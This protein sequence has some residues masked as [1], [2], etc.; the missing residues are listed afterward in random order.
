MVR[1][2]VDVGSNS[3][4]TLVARRDGLM[5]SPV[6]ELSRVTGLGKGVRSS[7]LLSTESMS[8]T[9]EALAEAFALARS[10]GASR[11]YAGATMA[12]RMATNTADFVAAAA[13]QGTPL[14]VLSS[15]EEARLGFFAVAEDPA[16][17]ASRA[18]AVVDPGGQSTE[19]VVAHR[20][21]IEW[22]EEL[23]TSL[24]IGTWGLRDEVATDGRPSP[25]QLLAATAEVDAAA[26]H[27]RPAPE[28]TAVVL[29][30]TGTNLI[31]VRERMTRWDPD[32][33][34]GATLEYEEVGRAVGML[35]G[36]DDAGRAALVGIEPGRETTLH[37]GALILERLLYALRVEACRV[38]TRGWR[39]AMLDAFDD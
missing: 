15:D 13:T 16:F 34:H 39:H 18:L 25:Q 4:L 10:H 9:L 19:V 8:A 14:H 11:V 24:R 33:V 28:A 36:L 2:V 20:S 35:C 31:T 38:S 6:A 27:V 23:R 21:S 7:R 32:R 17:A 12:A 3:V 37:L 5:W 26:A 1:A 22:V 29:G 30:A